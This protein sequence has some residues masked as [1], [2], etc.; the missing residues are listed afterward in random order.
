MRVSIPFRRYVDHVV[1]NS[2]TCGPSNCFEKGTCD[3]LMEC[4][5]RV[6]ISFQELVV[7]VDSETTTTPNL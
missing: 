2:F 4:D 7:L 3:A 1:I 5:G 6:I